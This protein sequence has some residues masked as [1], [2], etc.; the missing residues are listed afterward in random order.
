MPEA[1]AVS[2]LA[3]RPPEYTEAIPLCAD[4]VI[5]IA[6][7]EVTRVEASTSLIRLYPA[8]ISLCRC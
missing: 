7:T 6:M 8:M 1:R 2:P 4:A 5:G 3:V